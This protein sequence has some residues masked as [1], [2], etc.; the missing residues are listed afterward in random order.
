MFPFLIRPESGI[1]RSALQQH[2][3][4]HGVDTRMVWTGNVLRQPAFAKIEHRADPA[5]YP[6][7]DRVMEQGLV[8]PSNHGMNDDDVAYVCETL[9]A[10]INR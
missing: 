9:D 7:A 8:L 5:G 1:R 10:F 6:N 2:M 3:E 4:S